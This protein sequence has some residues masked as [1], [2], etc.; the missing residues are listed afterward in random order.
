MR[1]LAEGQQLL[2]QGKETEEVAPRLES[3][4]RRG[5]RG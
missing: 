1:K 4:R 2:A 3:P 5:P